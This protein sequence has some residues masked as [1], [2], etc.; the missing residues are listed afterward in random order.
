MIFEYNGTFYTYNKIRG[1]SRK[2]FL[3]RC[4]TIIKT[5]NIIDSNK[6]NNSCYL[7]CTY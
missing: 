3:K 5:N 4:I 7:G 6:K 2:H 1:E